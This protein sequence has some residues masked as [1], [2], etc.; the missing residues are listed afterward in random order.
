MMVLLDTDHI[1]VIQQES[2]AQASLQRRLGDV[3]GE[4]VYVSIVSFQEQTRG[5]LAYIHR[6]RKREQVLKGFSELFRLLTYYRAE[7]VLPF[8]ERLSTNLNVCNSSAFASARM[9]CELPLS[10]RRTA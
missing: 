6:A 8:D 3:P 7:R 4:D 10:P 1:S 2:E 9:T 5:W